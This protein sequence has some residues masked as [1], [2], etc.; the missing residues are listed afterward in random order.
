MAKGTSGGLVA[1]LTGRAGSVVFVHRRN[2][3]VVIRSYTPPRDPQTAAQQQWRSL[4]K[5]ATQGYNALSAAQVTQWRLYALSQTTVDAQTGLPRTPQTNNLYVTLA[6]KLLQA[7]PNATLPT[8]PPSQ[9]FV[10][11]GIKVTVTPGIQSVNF[12]ASGGNSAHVVTELLLQPLKSANRTPIVRSYRPAA[13]F[14]FTS[15]QLS[16]TV[17]AQS[18]WYACALRFVQNQTGQ[19]SAIIELGK[20]QVI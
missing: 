14:G 9:D 10:G 1:G 15:G 11:D 20:V 8:V 3:D 18:G 4:R 13:F 6:A 12:T 2:G 19:A 17:T 7:V 16:K 5:R